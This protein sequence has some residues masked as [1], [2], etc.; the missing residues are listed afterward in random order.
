MNYEATTTSLNAEIFNQYSNRNKKSFGARGTVHSGYEQCQFPSIPRFRRLSNGREG[1]VVE[2]DQTK[3]VNGA[4]VLGGVERTEKRQL[5]LV[6]VPDRIGVNFFG[7]IRTHVIPGSI[8]I[9]DSFRPYHN[10]DEICTHLIV[11][12][13]DT[14]RDPETGNAIRYQISPRNRAY[15]LDDNDKVVENVLNDH[16]LEFQ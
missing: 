8:I 9:T 12:H 7:I 11:N 15:S 4:S 16:L 13:S 5:F 14:F 1:I 3:I 6:D 2:L 10:L